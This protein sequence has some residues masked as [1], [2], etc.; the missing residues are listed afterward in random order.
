MEAES[1]KMEGRKENDEVEV[2]EVGKRDGEELTKNRKPNVNRQQRR[3]IL[4]RKK[5]SRKKIKMKKNKIIQ[6]EQQYEQREEEEQDEEVQEYDEEEQEK[7]TTR[8]CSRVWLGGGWEG[9][10]HNFVLLDPVLEQYE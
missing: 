2:E 1:E 7:A 5:S 3:G 8:K 9:S 4:R 10:T 6:E